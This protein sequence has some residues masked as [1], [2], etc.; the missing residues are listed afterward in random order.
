MFANSLSY[1]DNVRSTNLRFSSFFLQVGV[2]SCCAGTNCFSRACTPQR[3]QAH[4]GKDLFFFLLKPL[5]RIPRWQLLLAVRSAVPAFKSLIGF[6]LD[7]D[8]EKPRF[9]S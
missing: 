7:P 1:C 5:Q 4:D 8:Q 2:L 9:P 3:C 6:G